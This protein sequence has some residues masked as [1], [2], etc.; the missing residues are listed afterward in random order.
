MA[1][2]SCH[3]QAPI[4][5]NTLIN[6]ERDWSYSGGYVSINPSQCATLCGDYCSNFSLNKIL[7][8]K[9][10]QACLLPQ[11]EN[12]SDFHQ[13]ILIDLLDAIPA[14]DYHNISKLGNELGGREVF[15]LLLT[16][17]SNY[18]CLEQGEYTLVSGQYSYWML[19]DM[20]LSING[21]ETHEYIEENVIDFF[22]NSK[23]GEECNGDLK[24]HDAYLRLIKDLYVKE[25]LEIRGA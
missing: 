19:T 3:R 8:S 9:F 13:K 12:G 17:A 10:I 18:N 14:Q 1:F 6:N 4:T 16:K 22:L 23:V 21:K 5:R 7:A 11:I 20:I 24:T 2:I 15:E 25:R